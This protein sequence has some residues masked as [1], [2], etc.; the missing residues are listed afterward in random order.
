MA[1]KYVYLGEDSRTYPDL[2]LVVNPG[3]EH[4]LDKLPDDGR[5]VTKASQDKS[6]TPDQPAEKGK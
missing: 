2:G 4:T 3:E 6:A 1:S 5:W